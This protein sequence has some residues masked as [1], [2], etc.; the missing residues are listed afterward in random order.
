VTDITYVA[1]VL[2]ICAGG[3]AMFYALIIRQAVIAA[4]RQP[5]VTQ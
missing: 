4:G 5:H 1:V 2:R 3:R